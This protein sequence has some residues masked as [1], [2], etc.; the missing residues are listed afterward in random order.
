[1]FDQ[2]VSVSDRLC[3]MMTNTKDLSAATETAD[4]SKLTNTAQHCCKASAY[5]FKV[6]ETLEKFGLKNF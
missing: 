6:S 5:V 4:R 2:L 1:M 3:S